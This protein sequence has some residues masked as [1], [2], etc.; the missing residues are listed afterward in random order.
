MDI[1]RNQ[2]MSPALSLSSKNVHILLNG[3]RVLKGSLNE[4]KRVIEDGESN[5]RKWQAS[6]EIS[7]LWTTE[8]SRTSLAI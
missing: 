1:F 8:S 2:Q 7:E 5:G 4:V 3:T 6:L